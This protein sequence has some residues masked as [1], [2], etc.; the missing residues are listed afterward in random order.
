[1]IFLASDGG[2]A[3]VRCQAKLRNAA[4]GIDG[5]SELTLDA[6]RA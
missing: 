6:S 2:A 5:N 4:I 3:N 1:M